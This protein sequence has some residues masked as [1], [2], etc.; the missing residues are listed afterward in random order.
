MARVLTRVESVISSPAMKGAAGLPP[1]SA[2][3]QSIC[4]SA[5]MLGIDKPTKDASCDHMLEECHQGS[6]KVVTIN[7]VRGELPWNYA[8]VSVSSN[9]PFITP[10]GLMV[11][12]YSVGCM[13]H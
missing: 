12:F 10:C 1:R 11:W 2:P 5:G 7:S 8:N 9:F 4:I 3:S 13:L 6:P